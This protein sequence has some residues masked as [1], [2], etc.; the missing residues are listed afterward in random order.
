MTSATTEAFDIV[1]CGYG[2]AG[3]AAAIEATDLGARVLVAEKVSEG[4]GSTQESG[5][6]LAS[7]LD[8]DGAV[9]HYL[10]LTEGRTPRA[11]VAAYVDGVG[12]L[13]EW[14]S[15][16][17]ATLERL[18]MARPP[19]PHR[20]EGSAYG[21]MPCADSIGDRVR[22]AEEGFEHGGTTLW[23]FLDRN[24]TRRGIDVRYEMAANALIREGDDV[25]G[26]EFLV[27]GKPVSVRAEQGVILTCGGFACDTDM[28]RD[29]V[30]PGL[31]YYSPPG[32]NNGD[33][34]RMAQAIGADLWHM[35]CVAAGFGYQ[36]P[37]ME[38]A[39]MCSIPAFG[40][41]MVDRDGRRFLNEPAIEHHAANHAL[42][43]REVHSGEF[44]RLPSYLIFDETTRL[45]GRIA[46]A[47]AGHN[48]HTGWSDD[49]RD[50]IEKGWIR[51]GETFGELADQLGIPAAALAETARRYN[52]AARG[53][54]DEMG[55]A[56]DTLVAVKTPPLYGIE[57]RPSLFNTQG[58]PRRNEHGEVLDTGGR[59]IPGL[60]E[61]GELG[62]MW[63]ALYP[64]AG[65]VTE[66]LVSGR[67]AGRSAATRG[68]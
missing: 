3:A 36:V 21:S 15:S 18:P 67:I 40:F 58:G 47:E 37:G 63:A 14:I 44:R 34:V 64:G 4:G 22:I 31:A 65:N 43:V 7:I 62:S 41:F 68:R 66:A 13:H 30:A 16:N 54:D 46:T 9:E 52:E 17:G 8:R 51:R 23:R 2:G 38:A 27:G 49:N 53:G 24:V 11:V 59:P 19:F 28:V 61:A 12:E 48:R 32:R 20:Y 57:V 1:I 35:S 26:V 29:A 50:E 60:F 55:R 10:A 5:G 45:A 39:W 33:G 42:V 56:A 6:S 25:R